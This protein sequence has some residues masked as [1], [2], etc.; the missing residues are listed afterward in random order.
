M[1]FIWIWKVWLLIERAAVFMKRW[2][3]WLMS[4]VH[5]VC[6]FLITALHK[7]VQSGPDSN[8]PIYCPNGHITDITAASGGG[9]HHQ[10]TSCDTGL[11]C[12]PNGTT[13]PFEPGCLPVNIS[14]SSWG[15]VCNYPV[16]SSGMNE[17]AGAC[18][19]SNHI[20]FKRSIWTNSFTRYKEDA[21]VLTH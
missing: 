14:G 4:S 1:L 9:A 3:Y 13:W 8:P 15:F 7:M 10:S 11:W 17:E 16:S 18:C 20:K 12:T 2:P 19:C 5:S 21:T 6:A